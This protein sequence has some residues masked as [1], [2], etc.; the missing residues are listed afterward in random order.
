M[1]Y[2]VPFYKSRGSRPD[3]A[4]ASI[5][6]YLRRTGSHIPLGPV[7]TQRRATGIAGAQHAQWLSRRRKRTP[8]DRLFDSRIALVDGGTLLS[9]VCTPSTFPRQKMSRRCCVRLAAASKRVPCAL[10]RVLV[11][12]AHARCA[13]TAVGQ[14]QLCIRDEHRRR[15]HVGL[16]SME[17]TRQQN[18]SRSWLGLPS[19]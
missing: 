14:R 1:H 4:T 7:I 19:R 15:R 9:P 2:V 10:M 8:I 17:L 11:V 16:D 3:F 5:L 6:M 18:C 13:T 12:H